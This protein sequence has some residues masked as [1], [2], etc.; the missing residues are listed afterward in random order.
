MSA[1]EIRFSVVTV[2]GGYRSNSS[3]DK[4]W[5]SFR[6]VRQGETV[7]ILHDEHNRPLPEGAQV[8]AC[9]GLSYTIHEPTARRG[10]NLF[11]EFSRQS[12]LP[13]SP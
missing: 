2:T 12:V 9:D 5:E 10:T 1:L 11:G 6:R 8:R 3:F 4:I 13:P 7:I